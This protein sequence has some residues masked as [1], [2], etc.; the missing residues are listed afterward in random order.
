MAATTPPT[1][2]AVPLAPGSA[3]PPARLADLLALAARWPQLDELRAAAGARHGT[4]CHN[5]R[6][7][8]ISSLVVCARAEMVAALLAQRA[9]RP[10]SPM[11]DEVSLAVVVLCG[12][13]RHESLL[14]LLTGGLRILAPGWSLGT[15]LLSEAEAGLHSVVAPPVVFGPA[16]LP[17]DLYSDPSGEPLDFAFSSLLFGEAL[18]AGWPWTLALR[19]FA[20]LG[21]GRACRRGRGF[22]PDR[23]KAA[24]PGSCWLAGSLASAADPATVATVFFD[25]LG[26][27][28]VGCTRPVFGSPARLRGPLPT[29]L[30]QSRT[31]WLPD[32]VR[33]ARDSGGMPIYPAGHVTDL[34]ERRHVWERLILMDGV[35]RAI[36]S[37][38]LCY[39]RTCWRIT[40]SYLPNHKS[41]EVA[42]VKAKLGEKLARYFCQG[43]IEFVAPG[44]VL[45]TIIEP[46]GAVPKK[47]KDLFRDI[48]DGREGNKSIADWGSRLFTARDLAAALSW[49]D[50]VHGFDVNDG[51]HISPFPGCTGELVLGF[52]VVDVRRIFDG[53]PDFE[54]PT[55]LGEDG[56]E[57]P[58]PGPHGPQIRFIFGW[59]LHLGCWPGA[60][61]HTCDKSYCGMYF[62]GCVARWAV[63]HFG[64][65]PAGCPLNCI[66][67]CLLRHA[68][69]RG[70]NTGE[71]RGA[72]DRSMLGVVW[73]DDFVFHK[74]VQWHEPCGGLAGGCLVCGRGLAAAIVLDEWWMDLNRQ[75][76]VSLNDDKHQRCKQAVEYAGF[77]FDTFRGLMLVLPDKQ[78]LLLE[79]AASLGVTGAL[80]SARELDSI[81]GRLLHYSA[82]VRHLRVL[83]TELQR[84]MGPVPED[85]YDDI[86]PAPAGLE[87]LSA[88]MCSVLARY[89]PLGRPLWPPPASSAYATF[90]RGEAPALFCALTWD[91]ST[92]GWAALARWWDL[93]GPSPVSRE[94]LLVGTWPPDWDVSEQPYREGLGGALSFEAFVVAAD[95]RGRFCVLRNDA[96]AAIAAFR[97]GSTQSPQM[98]RCAL[99]LDRAAARA[100][101][102]C[103]PCHVPGLV[104]VAEG[105]DGASRAGSELGP[106]ANVAAVLGPAVDDTVWSM[107]RR[108][109]AAAGWRR[110]TVDAFASASNARAPRFWSRFLEPGAEAA[111]ALCLL[112]WAQSVCPVCGSSHRE[113]LYAFPPLGLVSATVEKACAD[114]ALCVLIVPV[115]ILAPHW[116]KLLYASALPI[117]APYLDGFLRIRSPAQHLTHSG[118]YAPSELAV[119]ACDF[120]RLDP[121]P[122]LP[123]LS[124]CPGAFAPRP[125]P[126]CGGEMDLRD[127]LRLREALLARRGLFGGGAAD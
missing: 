101:V 21:R 123:P 7:H 121:R 2:A 95:I 68:A 24:P 56:S 31:R 16:T 75:L 85:E 64:Q 22:L 43:A 15:Q 34:V 119:F 12:Q 124:S 3:R 48:A 42:A 62:D 19:L 26:V 110:V 80:W 52:G 105:V 104:L 61:S 17:A 74:R 58:A 1:P 107:A 99:R 108:A 5:R 88:E 70:A 45:P 65:K 116:S 9:R 37:G 89:A 117:A 49:R 39:P 44:M 28:Y 102:D 36:V 106:D 92:F 93:A 94:Q 118:D 76:G 6:R 54:P 91:A 14:S 8:A 27:V 41:W 25:D 59:R 51:Y 111:D 97:K 125:R 113:V 81:K 72:S 63:A 126:Q 35:T 13:A 83:V 23:S 115:A 67:L 78:L 53:D 40:P 77:L 82:G 86:G 30:V 66:A 32:Y 112:D 29:W 84:L 87:E 120:S 57:Q 47:G 20:G 71:L 103:L 96:A 98:Q 60:C 10:G 73:V 79:Q 33:L 69:L 46:K 50:I 11:A 18:A 4:S 122:G 114:R 127:R 100:N 38:K 55:V 109:A 90:L